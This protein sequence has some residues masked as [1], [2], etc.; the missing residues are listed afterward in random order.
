MNITSASSFR[1]LSPIAAILL[2]SASLFSVAIFP[3][4]AG[5]QSAAAAPTVRIRGTVVYAD[6]EKVVVKDRSG[7]VVSLTRLA[8]M[9]I[10]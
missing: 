10:S 1:R 7:E 4:T 3:V 2:T 6:R 5:A 8:E 9:P